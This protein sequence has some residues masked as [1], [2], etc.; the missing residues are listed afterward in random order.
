[1]DTSDFVGCPGVAV[2]CDRVGFGEGSRCSVRVTGP[3]QD[4][5]A[6]RQVLREEGGGSHVPEHGLAFVKQ[7]NRVFAFALHGP[8]PCEL[9]E[10]MPLEEAIP[11]LAG[12]PEPQR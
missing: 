7:T 10:Q 5:G 8:N 12:H 2:R 6:E 11:D 1:M 4:L 9:T 3:P